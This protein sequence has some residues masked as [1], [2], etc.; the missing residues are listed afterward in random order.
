MIFALYLTLLLPVFL[1]SL[2]ASAVLNVA[3]VPF[4]G[5]AFF[6]VGFLKPQRAWASLTQ[7]I[8]EI[9]DSRSDGFLYHTLLPSLKKALSEK[10]FFLV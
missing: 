9:Q 6:L 5:F 8:P 10:Y 1:F 2:F 3:T 4:L 7:V